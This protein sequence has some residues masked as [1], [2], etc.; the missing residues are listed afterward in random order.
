AAERGGV[1]VDPGDRAAHL[2]RHLAE[3]A[4][5]LPDLDEVERDEI[6]AGVDE[7][8]G[9]I[10]IVAR[11]AAEPGAAVDEHE[12]RRAGFA[13][14]VDVALLAV[15]RTV[16]KAQRLAEPAAPRGAGARDTLLNLVAARRVEA[17]VVGRIELDLVHV[18]PHAR[19][20]LVR[21]RPEPADG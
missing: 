11:R 9:R 19:T 6:G 8:L 2:L 10:R 17:L 20:L 16:G 7:Y 3:I 18:H 15:A 1:L 21:R 14:L 13:R 4:A 12:D 5:R